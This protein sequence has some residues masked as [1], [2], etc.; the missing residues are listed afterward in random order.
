VHGLTDHQCCTT[1]SP[2]NQKHKAEEHLEP[3][4]VTVGVAKMLSE[5][6]EGAQTYQLVL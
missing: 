3:G 1:G 5:V 2:K 4:S 6:A